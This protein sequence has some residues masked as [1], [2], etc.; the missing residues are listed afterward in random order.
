MG[1][2]F[3]PWCPDGGM[4]GGKKFVPTVFILGRDGMCATS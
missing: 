3:H 2:V 1:I 4:G